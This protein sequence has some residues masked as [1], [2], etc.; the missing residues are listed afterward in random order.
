[1]NTQAKILIGSLA[2][3]LANIPVVDAR[4]CYYDRFGRYRCRSGLS[5]AARIGLGIGIAAAALLLLGLL[6]CLMMLRRRRARRAN[7]GNFVA[8]GPLHHDKAPQQPDQYQP[9]PGESNY[10]NQNGYG[11]PNYPVNEP[12][13]PVPSYQA[14]GYAPPN[15]PPPT[16]YAPPPGPPPA[17]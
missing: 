17:K 6:F 8:T 9:Y 4:S 14:G 5:R 7:G 13:F 3:A 2:L 16:N 11:A 1:M 10:P 12:Q 15:G